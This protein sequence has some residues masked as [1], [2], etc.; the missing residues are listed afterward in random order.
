MT[1]REALIALNSIG[2]IGPV[3]VRKIKDCLGSYREVFS[4]SLSVLERKGILAQTLVE[5]IQK[6]PKD[7][8]DKELALV[9]KNKIRII[10]IEDENYPELLKEIQSPPLVL[11]VL[12]KGSLVDRDCIAIVGS[13]RASLYGRETAEH[14]G[15]YFS[16]QG[17]T[18]I[19]GLARGIDSA[20]HRGALSA[21]G[22][23][24][25]V[26]GSGFVH[27]YPPE[28]RDLALKIQNQGLLISEFSMMTPPLPKN[29]PKRNRI[30]S[31]LAKGVIVVEAARRS[32]SLITMQYAKKQ[33]KKTFAI[34]GKLDSITSQG[35][36]RLI[37]EGVCMLTHP[38]E[39]LE[40]LNIKMLTKISMDNES[41]EKQDDEFG[42]MELIDHEGIQVNALHQRTELSIP[43]LTTRLTKLELMGKIRQLPGQ[44][45]VRR[46]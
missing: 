27:M 28:N 26:L 20:A 15:W 37:K 45:Y 34:P 3:R 25:A 1:D 22:E 39:V 38:E 21:Q 24:I 33:G 41:K 42:L 11:Y 8:L 43:L 29:F 31:A 4:K 6:L 16:N 10:T 2:G 36:L 35:A 9:K 23:T 44:I 46:K 13:R 14:Y 17:L 12:G 19:S 30:I 7:W 32:G 40:E 5:K 18:V